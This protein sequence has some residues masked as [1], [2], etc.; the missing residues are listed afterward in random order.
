MIKAAMQPIK[1]GEEVERR[2]GSFQKL[3]ATSAGDLT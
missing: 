1:R 2:N 3:L